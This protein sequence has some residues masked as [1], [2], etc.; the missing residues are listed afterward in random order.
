MRSQ[1]AFK[2]NYYGRKE[3]E[4]SKEKAPISARAY[5]RVILSIEKPPIHFSGFS[6]VGM[7]L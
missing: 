1:L 7:L 2:R 4:S 3:K 5:L 6:Y